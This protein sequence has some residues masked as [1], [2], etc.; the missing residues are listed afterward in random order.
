M[1][2]TQLREVSVGDYVTLGVQITPMEVFEYEGTIFNITDTTVTIETENS[3][4]GD[5]YLREVDI[6]ISDVQYVH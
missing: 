3:T 6:K 2:A 5:D 4:S 1:S